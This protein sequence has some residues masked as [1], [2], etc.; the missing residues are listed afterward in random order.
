MKRLLEILI[1]SIFWTIVYVVF[2]LLFSFV[3]GVP[4]IMNILFGVVC[5]LFLLSLVYKSRWFK[6]CVDS[7][8]GLLLL[9]II[10]FT[11][12]IITGY[13][14]SLVSRTYMVFKL[15]TNDSHEFIGQ[16]R[17]K[18]T[19]YGYDHINN[20]RMI[21][22]LYPGD[23]VPNFTDRDGFRV[24]A[25]DTSKFNISGNVD[26]LFLGC[27]FT[28]G[29]FCLADSIFSNL[30]SKELGLSY[31]NA[32]VSGWGLAEMYLKAKELIP[33]Y[34][35]KYVVFQYSKWLPE[36]AAGMYRTSAGFE[37]AKPYF[38]VL[39]SGG[40]DIRKT[41]YA[42]DLY[43]LKRYPNLNKSIGSAIA[44]IFGSGVMREIFVREDVKKFSIWLER[45][46]G[47]SNPVTAT[48][49]QMEDLSMQVYKEL[50][51]YA[52]ENHAEPFILSIQ[53][54]HREIDDFYP[55]F[56]TPA[57][58]LIFIDGMKYH[59]KYLDSNTSASIKWDFIHW[60]NVNGDSV[61]MDLHPNHFSH[62]MISRAIV[63][64]LKPALNSDKEKKIR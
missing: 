17:Q 59:R 52:R 6:W 14:Q 13:A 60:R 27:S 3:S 24:P 16:L 48:D 51:A 4:F 57:D 5:S 15:L 42:S 20:S 53:N 37:M 56:M 1:I 26:V 8:M 32:G 23:T 47:R 2:Y 30:A 34:K 61:R 22:V 45:K 31:I 44:F 55:K 49:E 46:L 19:V 29:T 10:F 25:S 62:W 40:F 58:S 43:N 35:P 7:K 39:P 21:H 36:R 41:A 18:D 33:K 64:K 63:D 12:A 38:E 9:F 11:T 28:F 50:M 54:Q